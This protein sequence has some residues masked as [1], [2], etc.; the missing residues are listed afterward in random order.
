MKLMVPSKER[1]ERIRAF[2][3]RWPWW[4]V[5]L[6]VACFF[7]FLLGMKWYGVTGNVLRSRPPV[8]TDTTQ[9]LVFLA[10]LP[11]ALATGIGPYAREHKADAL[12]GVG[13]TLSM[14][15]LFSLSIA[16]RHQIDLAFARGPFSQER[17]ELVLTHFE[18]G[19]ANA[20]IPQFMSSDGVRTWRPPMAGVSSQQIGQCVTL[21]QRIASDGTRL[22][23]GQDDLTVTS[24]HPCQ[25]PLTQAIRR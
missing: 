24:F 14:L 10:G 25:W 6:A 17:V 7:G 1:R 2:R 15:Y 19:R 9:A 13:F 23:E 5:V 20:Q 22:I 21:T 12:I 8:G 4:R 16:E 3:G 11:V 18:A